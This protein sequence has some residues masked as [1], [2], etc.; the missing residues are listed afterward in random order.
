MKKRAAIF[1][2][3]AMLLL[4]ACG[5]G[6]DS[7]AGKT[8]IDVKGVFLL[9]PSD[10]LNLSTEGLDTVQRYL[11][12]VYDVD[13]SK[14]DSNVE[15]SGFSDAVEVTLNDTNTYEQCSGSTLIRNFIDNSGYTTPGECGTLWGGSEPVRMIS[16]FAVNQNDMKDGCTAK[17]NFNL[18]LNAQLRYTAEVAGTDIQTIAW[19][20]GRSPLSSFPRRARIK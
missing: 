10:Q 15:L 7:N 16:A 4:S 17:L 1:L 13:N 6:T 8:Q 3:F 11:F 5:G 9:E 18:S 2:L 19:P 14:N 20:D 12:A